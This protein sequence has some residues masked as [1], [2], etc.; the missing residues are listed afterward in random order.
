MGVGLIQRMR[1]GVL[2]LVGL[3]LAACAAPPPR[4]ASTS[5]APGPASAPLPAAGA[6][7]PASAPAAPP[8]PPA[9]VRAAFVAISGAM[10][11]AWLAAERS[12]FDR[13]GLDVELTYI[14][15]LTRIAEALL[16]GELDFG[17]SPAPTAMG[18]GLQGADLVMIASWSKKSI[19]SR[20]GH[21]SLTSVQDLRGKRIATSQ[22]GSLSEL[23]MIENL[24][25]YG[26]EPVQDYVIL[27]LGGQ[28]EQVAGLQNGAVDAAGLAI[29]TNILARKLGFR[30]ILDY[31]EHA[32]EHAGVGPITSKR[33]LA[34]KPD[35]AERFLKALAEGVAMMHR[36]TEAALAVLAD[37]TKMDDHE[38]LE[39]SLSVDRYRTSRDM[40]PTLEGLQAALDSLRVPKSNGP[41]RAP[42]GA[43]LGR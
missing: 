43:W 26:M 23:W 35:V 24:R 27:P 10:L 17:I 19:F 5:A 25:K 32:L 33:L 8:A 30:E 11:P 42:S 37:R 15:G 2:V 28:S 38:L 41:R 31:R 40:L 16:A 39:E 7:Q 22:R 21:P 13:Y 34:E 20:F 3:V 9:R 12:I 14:S 18:P 36:D 4:G 6:E 29:P 1:L